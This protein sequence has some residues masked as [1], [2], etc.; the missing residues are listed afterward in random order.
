[1]RF[2]LMFCAVL[3]T[4][5]GVLYSPHLQAEEVD[6]KGVWRAELEYQPNFKLALGLNISDQG[7]A[8]VSPNQGAQEYEVA[9]FSVSEAQVSFTIPALSARFQGQHENGSIRGT[10]TQGQD[11]PVAFQQ[12]DATDLT[13]QQREGQYAGVL[14][15][16]ANALPLQVNIAVLADGWLGTL[17]SPAQQSFGIPLSEV[18]IDAEQLRFNSP[19]LRASYKGETEA[20]GSYAGVWVQGVPLPL[21]LTKVTENNPAPQVKQAEFGDLG[22]AVAVLSGDDV[23]F[24]YFA[25]HDAT[26]QYEIGSVTKTFIAY[27][28]A[29]AVLREQV[30]L[31]TEVNSIIPAAP[32]GVT[33]EQLATHTS[34]LARLPADLLSTANQQDPYAHYNR[35]MLEASLASADVGAKSHS[36]SN[37]GFGL[38]AE[39]L[40]A[41]E[42][43]TLPDLLQDRIFEPFGMTAS[44]VA[45]AD[46]DNDNNLATPHDSLGNPV[47]PWRFRA[48]AGAG[49]IVSTLPDMVAY[50]RGMQKRLAS[51]P[52]LRELMLTPRTEFASCCQQA[53]GWMLEEDAAANTY[54]W[55]NGQTAGFSSYVGF[56]P[57]G[58]R[59]VVLLN[60]QAASI[61]S[62]AKRLLT[63]KDSPQN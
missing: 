25:E 20:L 19:L 31:A 13:R 5:S 45:L 63:A 42:E 4:A 36:Y 49:A 12:L 50:V 41:V 14:Q 10:F 59:A 44:Y 51:Q 16:G 46:S 57:D 55:H 58:S 30:T 18:R 48:L 34:G 6:L 9:D 24:D 1:M 61:N 22:G 54:V 47:S 32:A 26:T 33:L 60:N 37:Y 52:E 28:L 29:D 43:T 15:A 21:T 53:L 23:T 7:V 8:F 38:L 27:L 17:D 2:A 56:Y 39:A 35:A 11:F 3:L 40:A 62:E